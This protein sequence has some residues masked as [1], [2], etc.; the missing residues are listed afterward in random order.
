MMA[1]LIDGK[2]IAE[3]LKQKLFFLKEEFE[4]ETGI[5]PGLAFLR[6]GEDPASQI[7]V[8]TKCRQAQLL[9]FH[10]EEHSYS[11]QVS[12]EVLEAKIKELNHA[13]GVHG[14]ILQLPIP[15]HLDK[16]RLLSLINP[17]KDVDGLHPLNTGKLSQNLMGEFIPCAALGCLS[18]LQTLPL[19]LEGMNV[20]IV[21]CSLLVGRP[22]A[23]LM[24][25]QESTVWMAHIKTRNLPELCK[26]ADILI[27]AIGKP[28]FIQ[29]NWIKKG[30][31]VLDVGINRLPSG[32]TVGD[33]DFVSAQ[34]L[35]GAITPVPGGVGPMTVACLLQN[36]LKAAYNY[37][38]KAFPLDAVK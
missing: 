23:M 24:L 6:V 25:S 35:A 10:L 11:D 4:N 32:E 29:G 2:K 38:G 5:R 19:S 15:N 30:A 18:I 26:T 17:Q 14:I 36:T 9:G 27:V 16:F 1:E 13:A 3:R 28:G 12:S 33:V 7:Y 31:T 34:N 20:G 22:M 21:G 37:A 8:Q